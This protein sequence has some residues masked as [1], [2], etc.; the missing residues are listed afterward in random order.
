MFALRLD[1]HIFQAGA[2]QVE[3][4]GRAAGDE[5]GDPAAVLDRKLHRHLGGEDPAR[6]SRFDLHCGMQHDRDD[7]PR[8][9]QPLHERRLLAR[10]EHQ[11]AEQARHDIIPMRRI[12]RDP[13]ALKCE[14]QEFLDGEG[15]RPAG[16]W[17]RQ[18]R[19]PQM[20]PIRPCRR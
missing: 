14:R 4:A 1:Q 9:W 15:T 3:I 17:P 19:R 11:S 16:H 12:R 18:R 7:A 6:A 5:G 8:H 10:G 20:R 13:L 2:D